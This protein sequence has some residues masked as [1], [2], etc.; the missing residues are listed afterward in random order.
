MIPGELPIGAMR[1]ARKRILFFAEGVTLAHVARPISLARSLDRDQFE[2]TI[3]VH[4]RYEHLFTDGRCTQVALGTI[5][6][7]RFVNALAKG[8]PVYDLNT[9]RSY[10]REDLQ[11]IARHKPDVVVGDFRL[12]LSVSARLAK[13]PYVAISNAYWSPY[14]T[15][16]AFPLPVLPMTHFLPI[17]A[18]RAIFRMAWPIASAL[19]CWPLNRLR[20]EYGLYSLGSDLRSIY[21]DADVTVY[22]DVPEM[23]PLEGLPATHTF[24]G[25]V[26]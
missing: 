5:E 15:R 23:F 17:Y 14:C 6:S 24:I 4:P 26:E 8:R 7:D 21:T 11:L 18:A 12:S 20:Q 16:R 22:A 10:V 25:P 3:A 2:S 19:H 13:V 9:L 1:R